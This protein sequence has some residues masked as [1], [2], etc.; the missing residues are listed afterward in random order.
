M[1]LVDYAYFNDRNFFITQISFNQQEKEPY[2]DNFYK[3]IKQ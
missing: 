1:L 3:P 2:D